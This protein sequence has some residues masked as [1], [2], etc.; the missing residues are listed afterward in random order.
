M[1]TQAPVPGAD[2]QRRALEFRRRVLEGLGKERGGR[3]E[4]AI[5]RYAEGLLE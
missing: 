2:D 3:L 5:R 4:P 1:Q